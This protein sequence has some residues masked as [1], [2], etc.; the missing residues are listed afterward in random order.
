MAH[1]C[2]RDGINRGVL[3]PHPFSKHTASFADALRVKRH[4]RLLR[5]T[6]LENGGRGMAGVTCRSWFQPS[7]P[8]KFL[9]PGPVLCPNPSP[10]HLLS[11][12]TPFF[13][14]ILQG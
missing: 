8:K 13:Y 4:L 11:T 5:L 1:G 3:P 2:L 12:P 6:G 14:L 7:Q 10:H 9:Y